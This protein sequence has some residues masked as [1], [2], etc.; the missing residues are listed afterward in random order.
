MDRSELNTEIDDVFNNSIPDESLTPSDEGAVMK[1]IADYIDQFNNEYSIL[2]TQT[3]TNTPTA[4][5]TFRD[6]ITGINIVRNSI[7]N[8]SW[9]KTGAFPFGKT[10][11]T[12]TS[13]YSKLTG[14]QFYVSHESED[15]IRMLVR[16]DAGAFADLNA[17]E[18]TDFTIKI[19]P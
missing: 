2:L 14:K 15:L 5:Y 8:Y 10:K 16:D 7:G 4:A 6:T 19:Y 17:V 9:S 12:P 18:A 13:Y 11:I 3:G 1:L